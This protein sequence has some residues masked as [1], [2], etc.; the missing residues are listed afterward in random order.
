MVET[1][2]GVDQEH[3]ASESEAERLLD[4]LQRERAAFLNYKRRVEQ[5]RAE[6]RERARI[7]ALRH[8]FPLLDEL[9][10]ALALTPQDIETHPWVQG[11][12]LS[13]NRLLEALREL[14]AERVGTVG[15][16]FDPALHDALFYETRPDI[17]ERK[18]DAVLRPGYRLG[19]KLL[20]PAQVSVVGPTEES[21]SPASAGAETER[22]A[23][24]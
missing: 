1:D 4:S 10:Q 7:D 24:E 17:D 15:E 6:D 11:V 18:V 8:L 14:G 2:Q 9:E 20:R 5:D 19:D 13:R 16:P 21:D 22:S 23:E 12:T 3:A